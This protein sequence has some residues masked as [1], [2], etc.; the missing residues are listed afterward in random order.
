MD[1]WSGWLTATP[2]DKNEGRKGGGNGDRIDFGGFED[3]TGLGG[4]TSFQNI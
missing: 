4:I 2:A 3:W 1:G